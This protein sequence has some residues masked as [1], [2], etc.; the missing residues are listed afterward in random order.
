MRMTTTTR[1]AWLQRLV[2]KLRPMYGTEL[3]ETVHVS[4]GFPSKGIRSKAVGECWHRNASA[5]GAP[6]VYVH[7]GIDDPVEVAAILVHELIHACRPDAAH[8]AGFR[9]LAVPLGL[10]GRMTATV[11][12]P[13]LTERLISIVAKIGPYPHPALMGCVVPTG[14]KQSTRM[15]KV[16]C[17]TCDYTVRTTRKW[18]DVG[19]PSCP[20][21]DVMELVD[22]GDEEAA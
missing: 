11:A 20:E 6:Q 5:D 18:L 3:P 22:S 21:G 15:L 7:P 1:E 12:G 14:G 10:E 13:A 9:E 8:G 17:A 19:L 2:V 4:V 16:Q